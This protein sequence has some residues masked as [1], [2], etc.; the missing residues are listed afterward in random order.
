MVESGRAG[1]WGWG[2]LPLYPLAYPSHQSPPACQSPRK[3]LLGNKGRGTVSLEGVWLLPRSPHCLT[4]AFSAPLPFL[5]SSCIV[6]SLPFLHL[7]AQ[8]GPR[9]TRGPMGAL[10]GRAGLTSGCSE[11]H[12]GNRGPT[13]LSSPQPGKQPL[14]GLPLRSAPGLKEGPVSLKSGGGVCVC[15]CACDCVCVSTRVHLLTR[16][17][18]PGRR[19]KPTSEAESGGSRR[20][21][22]PPQPWAQRAGF[23]KGPQTPCTRGRRSLDGRAR[24]GHHPPNG[25]FLPTACLGGLASG[26]APP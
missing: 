11:R 18:D 24:L 5:P 20:G 15:E 23:L 8:P 3:S 4:S 1:G 6:F 14:P 25:P 21:G 22:L 7:L 9:D 2:R 26:P 13:G 10:E 19:L 17:Q 16:K 12:Q